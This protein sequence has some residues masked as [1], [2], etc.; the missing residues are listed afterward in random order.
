M[1]HHPFTRQLFAALLVVLALG[2]LPA[3]GQFLRILYPDI[4]QGS[5]VLVV[6]PTGHALLV[7]AG[8]GLRPTDDDIALFT[9]RLIADGIVTSIDFVVASHYDEDHIGRLEDVLNFGGVAPSVIAYDR[10]DFTRTPTTFAFNDY[11]N[12]ALTHNRTTITPF[13]DLDLGGGVLVE[14]YAVNGSL[15]D[16]STIDIS[17]SGQ[18]ENSASVALVVR[19]G[20]FDAW[21]GGD[22]T[23]NPAVGV[24]DIEGP[25]S[26]LVG[27]L[28]LY[29]VD[30]H[31]S[32]TSSS[33]LFL[34]T[35]K[36]EVAINQSSVTNGFGHP[37][38]AVVTRFLNT[39]DTAGAIP[40]FFQLN[41]GDPNDT[42]SDDALATG[43][44]DP[45]DLTEVLGLPGTVTVVSDGDSY[46][47]SGGNIAPVTLASDTG[48]G[49]LAD[50][51]PAVTIVSRTPLVPTAT[52]A[53]S[54]L[55][56]VFDEGTPAVAIRW[57]RDD[58]LQTPIAMTAAGGNSFQAQV[59]PL[60]D[61]TKV[62]LQVQATDA[63]GQASLS[64]R[65]GYYAGTTPIATIRANDANGVL[66]P[67]R[68]D[69]R[70]AGNVTA[71]P[72]IFHPFVSQIYVQDA[73][74][75]V[76]V[77]DGSL[78]P[79]NRADDAAF[80]GR[81]E[82]F[83]GQTELNIS[84]PFGNYGSTSLGAGIAPVPLVVTAS[85][86][87]ESL[88]GRL[89]QINGL[90]VLS[91]TI[92]S[93]GNGNLTVTDDGGV[94]TLTLHID[95][96]TDIP[97][98]DTP[99][100]TFDLIGIAS[101]FDPGFPFTAGY[102]VLPRERTD[103]I[104]VEVNAPPLLINEMHTDPDSVQGDA[105]GD[106]TVS[107][108]QDEFLELANTTFAPLDISGWQIADAIS[109]RH[110]FPPGTVVPPRE[111]VVVFGGGTPTGGFGNAAANGLVFTA[112]KGRLAL[113]NSGDTVTLSDA[114]GAVVQTVTYGSQGGNN[115]S[116]TRQSDLT[117]TPFI[118]HTQAAPGVRFSPGTR[119]DG[120]SFT[121][122]AGSVILTEVMYDPTGSDGGL[123]WIELTNTTS[124]PIDLSS[125]SLGGGGS[126]YLSTVV[127][128]SGTIQ[129]QSTFVVGGPTSSANNGS[130]LFDQVKDWSPD[131]QNSG[132]TA[133]GVALFNVRAAQV[134]A[135][136]VPIDAVVYG[137]TNLNG[138]IDETGVANAPDVGDASSG[139]SIERVDT[140]GAW[141]IQPTPTPNAWNGAGGGPPPPPP[142]PPAVQLVLS[143]VLYDVAGADNGLEWVE[144]KN[145]GSQSVDLS[146]FS[147]GNGGGDYT[148]S[149]VQLA[150]TVAPGAIFVVGGPTSSAA[151]GAPVFDQV[152]NWSPDFQNSGATADGVALFDL[153]AAQVTALTVPIDAVVY[154]STNSNNLIDETGAANPPEVGDAP[155]GSSIE[156]LDLAGA[157]QIQAT[158]TP[159]SSPL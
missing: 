92:P 6:S 131:L 76:Q 156:R 56:Q 126:S 146:G 98:A 47:I 119:T 142:P 73:T 11:R 110:V 127:Q 75:G 114:A 5:S 4:E 15:R 7:D 124:A 128:L 22:L 65:G 41:R 38:T 85:Q 48:P 120:Q 157:W 145:T 72:G 45:D 123:E 31:G 79:L 49:F 43:I 34:S 97:G 84:Q 70:I 13:T 102:Q 129:A 117:N 112:S 55:A 106:G 90:S 109:L 25:T 94:S 96:D 33:A 152:I 51:P 61:G 155:Q 58:V 35:I 86:V 39:P 132:A 1:F 159:G 122:A 143:E 149:L 133:D 107:S 99:T 52:E 67:T 69:V 57:W 111:V 93:A 144:I 147:L 24:T 18:F 95:G 89:V 74:G 37:N 134:T 17:A 27:D 46:Q 64:Q 148:T 68:F 20:N 108:S 141:Q 158:P 19:F 118:L 9:Q 136:T 154:G 32:K 103:F 30:H 88:E 101:Q 36:A 54:V 23:G 105:N 80:V 26:L 71:E 44:A 135:L 78:L 116:L 77:F 115:Q 12:A 113:N 29:T 2:A 130:P 8:T 53:A 14:C 150:G 153:P 151:N 40:R 21:I 59:P 81:L 137:G 16:G 3:D 87:D 42:R 140:A 10:G 82:L 91:G 66:I 121:V 63:A 138:L 62:E 139:E 83:S 125:L 60:P 28:D 104:S 50:F 100:Q